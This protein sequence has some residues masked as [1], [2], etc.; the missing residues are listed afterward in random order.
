MGT[1][2]FQPIRDRAKCPS[3]CPACGTPSNVIAFRSKY[4]P[5]DIAVECDRCASLNFP[6]AVPP[7]YETLE[8]FAHFCMR[9]DQADSI[10]AVIGPLL[11]SSE[12]SDAPV[13]DVGCGLGFAGDFARFMG[14]SSVAFDPSPSSQ[15]A[16]EF[17]GMQNLVTES[18]PSSVIPQG[19]VLV[20]ASEVIE[21]VVD[22]IG[23]LGY[24]KTLAGELGYVIVTTPNAR[25][26]SASAPDHVA[27]AM[28]GPT[29][30]LQ[31]FSDRG[32]EAMAKTVGFDWSMTWTSQERLFLIAGP[33]EVHVDQV[34]F[35]PDY[36]RYLKSKTP[37]N[38]AALTSA[39][40]MQCFGYR[41]YKELVIQ[42]D[43][44]AAEE[45]W[46]KL[47]QSYRLRSIDL[48]RPSVTT[49]ATHVNFG[50][51]ALDQSALPPLNL[52]V[53]FQLRAT[54]CLRRRHLAGYFR[55]ASAA[56]MQAK[57]AI[58]MLPGGAFQVVDLEVAAAQ[59]IRPLRGLIQLVFDSLRRRLSFARVRHTSPKA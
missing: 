20:F 43:D 23:F 55:Y 28:L 49:K 46:A 6:G 30:H 59:G 39:S 34:D 37:S 53:L 33:L 11:A 54:Q 17:L 14:R 1:L 36:L 35:R 19:R 41:L 57:A 58:E 22:P 25:F 8:T 26:L 32:L 15:W 42:G 40:A 29:Q 48:A 51:P 38:A 5:E 50:D 12:L 4:L 56:R 21:H 47:T 45:V 18:P 3:N 27:L 24:L 44:T 9:A 2:E 10:D 31:L 16:N 13:I 7:N 52:A